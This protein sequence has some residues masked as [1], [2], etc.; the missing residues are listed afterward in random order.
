MAKKIIDSS[1]RGSEN[2]STAAQFRELL[3]KNEKPGKNG[4]LSA[5]E[6]I[7][8]IFDEG[9]FTELGAYTMRR[10]SEYD[11][12]T[13]DQLESVICGYGSVNGC[14]VYAFA[15]DLDRTKGS[16][17]EAA[18][19]KICATYKLATDN[20]CPIVG[21]FDSAGA[22][23][24][25]GVRALAGYGMIMKAVSRASGIIPQ[26]AFVPGIAQGASAVIASMFDFVVATENSKVSVNPPFVV[27]GGE[28]KDSVE[29]G[30]ASLTAKDDL[31]A[32]GSIRSLLAY[33][34]SNNEEGIVEAET[35]DEVNR[36]VDISA[37]NA[38]G[39]IKNL[40]ASFADDAKYLELSADYAKQIT[41]G[42]VTLG[43][44]VCGVVAAN[45]A[46]NE[47]R[48]TSKAARKAA[49]F[50]S[51]CDCF[52]VPV[53]TLVDS[54]GFAVCGEEEKNPYSSE[55]GKL[56]G[57]YAGAKVPLITLVAGKAYGSVFSVLGSKAIG[58]D[59][60][61]ALDSA[62][63]SCMSPKSAVALLWNDKIKGD[64]TRE[65]LEAE[66]SEKVA[67]ALE[68]ARAG[69]VDDIIDAGE[70]R[71]RLASAVLM[72]AGKAVNCPRKRHANMPL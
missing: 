49:K 23:L 32:I 18:A 62:K 47:G 55:I 38:D 30:I 24:P 48:L 25:E 43:G 46:E 31:D 72:L 1:V 70:L 65:D 17:S 29:A 42:F 45:H 27:G 35:Y 37:Y 66:W 54:E 59:L 10:I 21:V 36:L 40:I 6:R 19:K 34:P 44:A 3:M 61:L 41:T 33:L 22:Y 15:Q 63:I 13:P 5:R 7:T 71:Q 39:N 8:S 16:V 53:I 11:G 69:E 56:A 9:T 28:T 67:S 2:P 26:I 64:I 52:G 20:G 58:A 68:A 50:V 4:V 57:A 60:V 51:F 14:L 12:E